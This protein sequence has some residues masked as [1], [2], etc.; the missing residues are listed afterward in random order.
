MATVVPLGPRFIW[1]PLP[2][3]QVIKSDIRKMLC[4]LLR[5]F[6]G[7]A[8]M[9][10]SLVHFNSYIRYQVRVNLILWLVAIQ[11]SLNMS[12]FSPTEQPW[13]LDWN[14]LSAIGTFL[15]K[16][17]HPFFCSPWALLVTLSL[18]L[19]RC[20]PEGWSSSLWLSSSPPSLAWVSFQHPRGTVPSK[21][22]LCLKCRSKRVPKKVAIVLN[23]VAYL[24]PHFTGVIGRRPTA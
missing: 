1:P 17:S 7:L 3:Y 12:V 14:Q 18:A 9:I 15:L 6:I 13:K 16:S 22:Y 10:S 19:V 20:H 21:D 23:T 11:V 5:S 24:F 4:F 8:F 2:T